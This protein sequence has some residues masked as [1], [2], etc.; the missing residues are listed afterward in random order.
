MTKSIRGALR[1]AEEEP[2]GGDEREREKEKREENKSRGVGG[3]EGG[4]LFRRLNSGEAPS[5]SVEPPPSDVLR[6]QCRELP[7]P[8][9]FDHLLPNT[10]EGLLRAAPFITAARLAMAL[11]KGPR[12]R[13][14][15][16]GRS[17]HCDVLLERR[18]T[19]RSD[20]I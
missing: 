12:S 18:G 20:V 6:R 11:E 17:H 16:I 19:G 10:K 9:R 2:S 13:P 3:G 14:K 15:P 7:D 4:D 1:A 5:P 8:A